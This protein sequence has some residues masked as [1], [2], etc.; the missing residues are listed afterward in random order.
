MLRGTDREAR[1]LRDLP[2]SRCI[3]AVTGKLRYLPQ[4]QTFKI[5]WLRLHFC[6]SLCFN[7]FKGCIGF[8]RLAQCWVH[9]TR[10]TRTS[11]DLDALD[12]L[13]AQAVESQLARGTDGVLHVRKPE[14]SKPEKGFR[15]YEQERLCMAAVSVREGSK[16]AQRVAG[17]LLRQ[18]GFRRPRLTLS[19]KLS[20]KTEVL[21]SPPSVDP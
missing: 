14:Q 21:C 20:L 6:H 16:S 17:P 12:C 4:C 18:S 10:A 13:H 11:T 2:Y 8:E 1:V 5:E 7:G 3:P 15:I 19:P 9:V